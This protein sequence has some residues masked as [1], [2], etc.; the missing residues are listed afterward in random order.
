MNL[1]GQLGWRW[2]AF[3]RVFDALEIRNDRITLYEAQDTE[4]QR[5]MY[6]ATLDALD[7]LG[8]LSREEDVPILVAMIP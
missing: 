8:R 4:A 5:L 2:P 6:S 3:R 7:Q 1:V